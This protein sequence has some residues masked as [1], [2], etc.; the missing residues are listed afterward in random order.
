MQNQIQLTEIDIYFPQLPT[1]LENRRI[2]HVSDLHCLGFGLKE[3][4]VLNI[5]REPADLLLCTGDACYQFRLANPFLDDKHDEH[6]PRCGLTRRGLTLR[7]KT[8]QAIEVFSRLMENARF[9]LGG[10]FVQGNH[11]SREFL[12]YLPK[13]GL[14]HLQNECRPIAVSPAQQFNLCGLRCENRRTP[15]VPKA[16]ESANPKLFTIGLSHYPEFG[17]PLAAGGADLIL[18]G[19][20]HGGQICLPNGRPLSTHS[21]TGQKYAAGLTRF[22]HSYI[23]TTRG[24]GFSMLHFRLFCPPEITRFTLHQGDPN[25][26]A[27]SAHTLH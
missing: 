10:Y 18:C 7:P 20:T 1:F 4:Q 8:R 15:D 3:Q 14:I 13:L 16:L 12:D 6:T 17:E 22:H 2:L 25:Q 11:D 19:H 26:T 23:Y 9:P 24:V 5:M 21:R 27:V